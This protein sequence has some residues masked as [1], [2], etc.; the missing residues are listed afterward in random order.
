MNV[1]VFDA[2][3]PAVVSTLEAAGWSRSRRVPIDGWVEALRPEGFVLSDVAAEVLS[4]LGGLEV[5]PVVKGPY[6]HPLLFEPVLAGGGAHDIAEEFEARYAQ[7]FYP[8]AEWISNACVFVGESGKVVSY[9]DVEWLE[10]GDSFGEA[11]EVFLL[12]SR[13]PKVLREN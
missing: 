7:R 5:P 9:D 3:P 8:V 12:A 4:S 1:G 2:L 11:L 10:I 13:S 6:A